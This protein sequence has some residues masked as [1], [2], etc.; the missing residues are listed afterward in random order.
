MFVIADLEWI[1]IDNRKSCPTQ[2]A[3]IRVDDLWNE[4]D[5]FYELIL[6]KN[7]DYYHWEHMA[8]VGGTP[9]EFLRAKTAKDVFSLFI[10]WLKNDD[11]VLWWHISSDNLFKCYGKHYMHTNINV[12][13]MVVNKHIYSY[14]N[15]E[16]SLLGDTYDISESYG[17]DTNKELQHCAINDAIVLR[18]LL[19]KIDYPQSALLKP[20]D[21]KDNYKIKGIKDLNCPYQYDP[22]TDMVHRKDCSLLDIEIANLQGLNTLVPVIKKECKI[23]SCCREDYH[24]AVRERMADI[25]SRSQFTYVYTPNS[26]I[27]H[28]HTCPLILNSKNIMGSRT[29]T[30]IEKSGR[31]PCKVCKPSVNDEF[32]AYIPFE[33]TEQDWQK[34]YPGISKEER[35]A[36]IRQK[37][38]AQ[39]R[40]KQLKDKSISKIDRADIYTITQSRFAFWAGQG[41][42]TF[43]QRSCTKLIGLSNLKGF[44]T[45][46]EAIKAGLLPC[47]KCKPSPKQ[48]LVISVPIDSKKRADDG[49]ISLEEQCRCAGYKYQCDDIYFHIET[50][51]GKWKIDIFSNPIK[52][53]HIN[54]THRSNSKNFHEQ[55]RVF[56][57]FTDTFNYIK[58]HDDKLIKL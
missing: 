25:I 56:L 39:E 44:R 49:L 7:A 57:S 36:L 50:P 2:L 30:P 21:E 13:T 27:F 22:A 11:V 37:A 28:K 34:E 35:K 29:Y 38:A 8:F 3:A 5:R 24:R 14:L 40:K 16:A 15:S 32:R 41:Y 6:P 58:R 45:Y 53:E 17:V 42:E 18:E 48:D 26:N 55:P 52:V 10:D 1:E 46:K 4:T 54:L 23:C 47:R 31:I 20:V 9:I 51:V 19:R 33:K 43:H 12:Q